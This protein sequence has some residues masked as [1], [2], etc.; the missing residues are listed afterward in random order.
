ELLVY[1]AGT[2]IGDPARGMFELSEPLPTLAALT[3]L[4]WTSIDRIGD[5]LRIVARVAGKGAV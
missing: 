1:L 5:D 4:Q 2:L 3:R